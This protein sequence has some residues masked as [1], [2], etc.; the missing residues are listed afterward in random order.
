MSE[1]VAIGVIIAVL[2][3]AALAVPW[4]LTR[5]V[6]KER[7]R[8]EEVPPAMRPGFSDEQ[9]EKTVIER[10]MGWG[11]VLTALF[12]VFFPV[13]W[14]QEANRLQTAEAGLFTSSV[15]TGE[16]LYQANCA[17]CHGGDGG[18]GAAPSPYSDASWPAPSVTNIVE[19][20]EESENVDDMRLFLT[21]VLERGR[22]GTPMPQWGQAYQGPLT[23]QEIRDIVDWILVNQEEGAAEE[24]SA[25]DMSGEEFFTANC[26]ECHGPGGE[27]QVG[28]SLVGVFERHD[29]DTILGIL[30]NGIV[31]SGGTVMP[32]FQ[33]GYMYEGT[34]VDDEM[35]ESVVDYLEELQPD[36]LPE[37]AGRYQTP[38]VPT[39][40]DDEEDDPET[41]HVGG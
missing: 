23:D 2:G 27:G 9:L 7:R 5:N 31:F 12:A 3:L 13:Y 21:E 11:L 4:F 30:R 40:G 6:R 18:G 32:A 22:P 24:V 41:A 1:A 16:A 20:Y 34:R 26:A 37:D 8:Y 29:E 38:G 33:N 15:A 39:H 25:T 10:Y 28:P 14:V 35:L 36:E 17:E 19:R